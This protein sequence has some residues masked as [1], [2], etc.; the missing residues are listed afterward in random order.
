MSFAWLHESESRPQRRDQIR[1]KTQRENTSKRF[2]RS[3][4]SRPWVM[5]EIPSMLS[6]TRFVRVRQDHLCIRVVRNVPRT[7]LSA[8]RCVSF[9][10]GVMI[11][12]CGG[13]GAARFCAQRWP[14]GMQGTQSTHPQGSR[15]PEQR[16][17]QAESYQSVGEY[18]GIFE[19]AGCYPEPRR[20]AATGFG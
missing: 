17:P 13:A 5:S 20:Q 9:A 3:A 7:G 18:F 1:Q 6:A 10:A 8:A 15:N 12:L 14:P 16:Q 19:H 4:Y 11:R 2:L